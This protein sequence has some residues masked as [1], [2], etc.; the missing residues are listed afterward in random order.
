M[1]KSSRRGRGDHRPAAVVLPGLG[2]A[3]RS[4]NSIGLAYA[5]RTRSNDWDYD[6]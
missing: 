2:D 5:A 4:A 3:G 1:A 6:R